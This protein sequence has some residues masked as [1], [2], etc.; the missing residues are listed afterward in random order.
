ME[1]RSW[2]RLVVLGATCQGFYPRALLG[3][4]VAYCLQ[5]SEVFVTSSPFSSE[6]PAGSAQHKSWTC[7][8]VL[9]LVDGSGETEAESTGQGQ[10]QGQGGSI[11]R[12]GRFCTLRSTKD[13]RT[14]SCHYFF[15]SASSIGPHCSGTLGRGGTPGTQRRGTVTA[16][17]RQFG[18][19]GTL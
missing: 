3:T 14:S 5:E 19:M 10:G 6:Q 2:A 12:R 8:E 16:F 17:S 7:T 11:R 4:L 1:Y 13:V 9:I 18:L 15:C